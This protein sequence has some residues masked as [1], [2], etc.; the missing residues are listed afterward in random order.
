MIV[1]WIDRLLM[2]AQADGT[3]IA[4]VN[5]RRFPQHA[6]AILRYRVFAIDT[7]IGRQSALSVCTDSPVAGYKT[8]HHGVV[9]LATIITD[10]SGVFS[11]PFKKVMC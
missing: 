8:V 6:S 4:I 7:V 1:F 10:F 11:E 2:S 3:R 5:H 9:L